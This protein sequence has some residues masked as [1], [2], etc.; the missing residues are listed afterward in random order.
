MITVILCSATVA[1]LTAAIRWTA[2]NLHLPE[3]YVSAAVAVAYVCK[4]FEAGQLTGWTDSR[5]S[6]L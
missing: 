1:Q 5:G 4:H 6:G 2:D 3:T